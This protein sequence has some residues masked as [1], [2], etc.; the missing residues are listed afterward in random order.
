MVAKTVEH[1]MAALHAY[2]ITNLLVKMQAEIPILDGS[3][4]EFCALIESAGIEEQGGYVDEIIAPEETRPR[5]IRS[6]EILQNKRD[7]NP[8]K[9]HGNIPL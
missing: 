3:A 1:L 2:G 9:K 8:P 4:A 5:L 7:K 6:L